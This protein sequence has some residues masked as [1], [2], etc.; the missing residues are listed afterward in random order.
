MK[1]MLKLLKSFFLVYLFVFFAKSY[2]QNDT[3]SKNKP[4]F[5]K[6]LQ[7]GGGL[8]LAIG[9]G[10][11]DIYLAPTAYKP[12]NKYS[13]VGVGLIGSYVKS[14]N[15]YSSLM[16]GVSVIGLVNPIE[17]IQLSAE[18][19]Q[20]RVN[21]DYDATIT[22]KTEENFWNTALFLGAGYHANNVTIGVRY[23]I[24][25]KERNNVYSQAWMPFVRVMF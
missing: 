19:E 14:S 11:T 23:N 12:I 2:A 15:F 18:L 13:T 17:E 3:L 4:S 5:F 24:L 9:N 16:Y 1:N 10:Y 25:Y 7:F 20:L 22:T 21:L 8:G 6:D